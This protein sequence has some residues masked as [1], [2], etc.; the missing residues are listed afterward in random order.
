MSL[1]VTLKKQ[2]QK[3]DTTRFPA[4]IIAQAE[5]EQLLEL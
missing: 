2:K 1:R 5:V 3:P 4:T